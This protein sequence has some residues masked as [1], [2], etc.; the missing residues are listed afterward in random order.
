MTSKK[1]E[2]Q[3]SSIDTIIYNLHN[4]IAVINELQD[5]FKE[6]NRLKKCVYFN[7]KQ[8][9]IEFEGDVS[10]ESQ[11]FFMHINII[12]EERRTR[13][14]KNIRNNIQNLPA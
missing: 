5:L 6:G 1:L 10:H 9:L 12:I 3:D 11:E 7:I 2:C 14:K 13:F 8:I 4:K